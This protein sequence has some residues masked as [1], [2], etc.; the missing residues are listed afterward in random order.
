[1]EAKGGGSGA[2]VRPARPRL[3]LQAPRPGTRRYLARVLRLV[4]AFLAALRGGGQ[5]GFVGYFTI[6]SF[7]TDRTPATLPATSLARLLT[8]RVSTKPLN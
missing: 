6:R 5:E 8:A 3:S 7:C 1:M 4:C 2:E